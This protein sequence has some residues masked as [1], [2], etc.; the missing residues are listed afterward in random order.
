MRGFEGDFRGVFRSGILIKYALWL[1]VVLVFSSLSQS[2]GEEYRNM[3]ESGVYRTDGVCPVAL[4]SLEGVHKRGDGRN[5][6]RRNN[7]RIFRHRLAQVGQN[8]LNS[9]CRTTK[10]RR[11]NGKGRTGVSLLL[12]N[13]VVSKGAVSSGRN[14]PRL[15]TSDLEALKKSEACQQRDEGPREGVGSK[16]PET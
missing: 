2:Q 16:I 10:R 6:A 11:V 3:K 5:D 7:Q 12:R 13:C 4:A 14:S 9:E 15:S 1:I 8:L